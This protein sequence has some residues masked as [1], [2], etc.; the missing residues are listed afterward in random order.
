MARL[1]AY[2][3]AFLLWGLTFPSSRREDLVG[4]QDLVSTHRTRPGP[5]H[6]DHLLPGQ[7]TDLGWPL[8][9]SGV[10][11]GAQTYRN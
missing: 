9:W 4:M 8:A 11:Q 1:A 6:T 3:S 2:P 5:V 7:G 10:V